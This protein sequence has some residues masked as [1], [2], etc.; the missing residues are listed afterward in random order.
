M[1]KEEHNLIN[2][3][4][5][6][7]QDQKHSKYSSDFNEE[8]SKEIRDNMEKPKTLIQE[9]RNYLYLKKNAIEKQNLESYDYKREYEEDGYQINT[10]PLNLKNENDNNFI[11]DI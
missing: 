9:Q 2:E 10:N 4:Y 3:N 6:E 1:I 8:D 7:N 11:I 5:E